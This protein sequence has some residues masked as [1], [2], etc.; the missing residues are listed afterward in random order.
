MIDKSLDMLD[1]HLADRKKTM[2]VDCHIDN[3]IDQIVEVDMMSEQLHFETK[4][5]C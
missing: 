4:K 1:N 2:S 5:I 3:I